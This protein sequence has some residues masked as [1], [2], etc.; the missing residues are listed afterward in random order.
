MF[1]PDDAFMNAGYSNIFNSL[2]C[3]FP[4]VFSRDD[5]A[6]LH[7]LRVPLRGVPN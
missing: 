6:V 5:E 7:L 2:R 3:L 4:G 1:N